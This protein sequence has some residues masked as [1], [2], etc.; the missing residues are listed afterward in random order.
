MRFIRLA[1]AACA[2]MALAQAPARAQDYP[3]RSITILVGLAPGGV[4]DVMARLY[5]QK[6]GEILKQTIVVENRPAASGA[7]AAAALQKASP[8][9]YMLLLFSGAQHATVPALSDN[10]I[11][12]P[13][14]GAQPVAV[15]FNFTGVVA[16]PADS[17]A[18]SIADLIALAKTKPQGL[19][20]GSPGPGTPSHLA[21]AKL[22]AATG[23]KAEFI[24]YKG[25]SPMMTDL[26]AGRLDVA[27]PSAPSAKTFL[28]SKKIKALAID[29]AQRWALVPNVPTL[30]EAGY[31]D[32]SV[33]N[34]FAVAAA[35]G[36]PPAIVAKLNA[37]FAQAGRDPALKQ[38]VEDLGLSVAT[39]TPEELGRL[40]AKEATDIRALIAKLGLKQ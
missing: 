10:A 38:R 12:D 20:F 5:A 30:A 16:V 25:G 39:S 29:G 26:V 7:V 27:W 14:A 1:L 13:V 15:V 24:H 9:G 8:D 11:Y 40:M 19:N 6:V 2:L 32:V 37:A 23:A 22:I 17:P 21:G 35:P 28:E 3:S 34:W 31:G 33:A 4:T 36:T 18:N